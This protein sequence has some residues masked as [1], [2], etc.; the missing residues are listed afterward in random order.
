MAISVLASINITN[1]KH[2]IVFRLIDDVKS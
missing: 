1:R 2:V